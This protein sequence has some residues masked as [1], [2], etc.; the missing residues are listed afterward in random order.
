MV[1]MTSLIVRSFFSFSLVSIISHSLSMVD[2]QDS[3]NLVGSLLV[4]SFSCYIY[5]YM[6]QFF[7]RAIPF[8]TICGC[9]FKLNILS[10]FRC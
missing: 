5:L 10:S 7:F 2:V 3:S 4:L 1:V 8:V 9:A 6:F